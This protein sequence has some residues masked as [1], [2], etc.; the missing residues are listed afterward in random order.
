[1]LICNLLDASVLNIFQSETLSLSE[2]VSSLVHL[3]IG[4]SHH[5]ILRGV[6]A[7]PDRLH[8]H[9][10]NMY[11]GDGCILINASPFFSASQLHCSRS[12]IVQHLTKHIQYVDELQNG[13]FRLFYI[14]S[15]LFKV[16]FYLQPK[17]SG[18]LWSGSSTSIQ[19]C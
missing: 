7:R 18:V 9:H 12:G 17:L 5:T 6:Q 10:D 11:M 16:T 1:M 19:A 4:L 13:L 14:Y 8:L 3:Y 15:Q 2:L